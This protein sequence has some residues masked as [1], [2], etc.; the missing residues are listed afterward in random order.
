MQFELSPEQTMLQQ[1]VDRLTEKYRQFPVGHAAYTYYSDGLR[2]DLAESGFLEIGW[3]EGCGPLDAALLV[4]RLARLPCSAEVAASALVGPVL[5]RELNG[6]LALC[7]DIRRPTR[8]LPQARHICMLAGEWVEFA[9]LD[10][11][12]VRP[13]DSVIAYPLG[14]LLAPPVKTVRLSSA[15]ADMVR[16]MWR[17]VLAAEAAGLMRGA[18]DLTVRHVKERRQFKQPLGNLQAIQHR[19]A[20]DE[21]LVGASFLLAMRAAYTLDPRDAAT[22][23]LYVQQHMRTLIYDC[24]QFTGAMGLTLEYPLHLW[25]YR[26]KFIQGELGGQAA[27]ADALADLI[28]REGQPGPGDDISLSLPMAE[29]TV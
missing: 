10:A 14:V 15:V 16:T 28:W 18:L 8:F 2:H 23:A 19:L 1:S 12:L 20:I 3:T 17:I 26:L 24:H 27:Q 22:A 4:E 11:Q 5:G 25:T 29:G 21:Q 6:P 13:H 7:E 9:D